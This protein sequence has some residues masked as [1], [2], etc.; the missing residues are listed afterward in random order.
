MAGVEPTN[1]QHKQTYRGEHNALRRD[2]LKL[3]AESGRYMEDLTV[4][5]IEA[6]LGYEIRDRQIELPPDYFVTGHPDG[7]LHRKGAAD[8]DHVLEDGCVWGFE[9]KFMGRFKYLK[10]FRDGL[11]A[12]APDYLSQTILYGHA[13]GWDKVM[14]VYLSQDASGLQAE[15]NRALQA[16]TRTVANSWPLRDDWN[17][18]VLLFPIDLR[19]WYTLVPSLNKRADDLARIVRDFGLGA[20]RREG[21]G[22]QTY[23]DRGLTKLAFPCGYC[24]FVDRCNADGNGTQVVEPMPAQLSE[25]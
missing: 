16:K 6:G 19:P 21:D 24:D 12:G 5:V 25:S 22:V 4:D 13:L 7:R 9:H 3:T 18:K 14:A 2:H 11:E 8:N 20:V 10:T 1:P 15:A 23:T 17:P